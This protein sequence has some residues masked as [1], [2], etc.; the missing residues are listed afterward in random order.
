MGSKYSMNRKLLFAESI[1]AELSPHAREAREATGKNQTA[2]A[3]KKKSAGKNKGKAKN[4]SKK[5]AGKTAKSPD[6]KNKTTAAG[7]QKSKSAGKAKKAADKQ[8]SKK[9]KADQSGK[10]GK[11]KKTTGKKSAGGKGQVI[12]NVLYTIQYIRENKG[13]FVSL[14]YSVSQY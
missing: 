4:K 9:N 12:L 7:K 10:S 1:L 14:G 8:K 2:V 3:G 6:N 13:N 11:S 5:T